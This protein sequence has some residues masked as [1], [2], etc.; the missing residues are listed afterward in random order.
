MLSNT[1]TADDEEAVLNE[2]AELQEEALRAQAPPVPAVLLPNAPETEPSST[3]IRKAAFSLK[4]S[5][6]FNNIC[7]E[8][9]EELVQ[10]R[11]QVAIEA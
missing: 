2:L 5:P 1:M 6:L 4:K 8:E 10:E 3:E 11:S 7:L 9:R